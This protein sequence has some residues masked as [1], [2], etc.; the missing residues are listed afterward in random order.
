MSQAIEEKLLFAIQK[1]DVKSFNALM[2]ETQCGKFRL[3]RFPV[4]SLMYLYNSRAIISLYEEKFIKISVW[5]ELGEPASVLK[6]FS[7]KAGKCLRLYLNEVVSPL[8]MLL[9]LDR[10]GRL[11]AMYPQTNPSN[12]VK[13]RLQ[14]VYF[15]KYSLNIKFE[16]DRII[17]DRR[18]LSRREK[19]KI[20]SAC[21][22]CFLA[23]AVA[24]AVPVTT[25]SYLR[26][27]EGEITKL[28]QIDFGAKTT[29]KLKKDIIVPR[30]YSVEKV[31]CTIIGDGHKITFGENASLGEFGGKINNLIIQTSGSPIFNVCT[32]NAVL[33][34]VTINVDADVETSDSSA[35][36]A[37]ANYGTFDG[38]TVNAGGKISA[39]AG[40]AEELI[41]GGI[42]AVN[43]NVIK[44]CTVNYSDF[45]IKGQTTANASFGGIVGVNNGLVQ[46]CAVTGGI[47]AYTFDLGGACYVNYQQMSRVSNE[48][49][50]TQVSE[51]DEWAPL[52]GGLVIDNVG[53]LT[54][55][56]NSGGI[57]ALGQKEA[58]CGGI[59]ARTYYEVLYCISSG[60]ITVTAPTVY[61]GGIYGISGVATAGWNTYYFGYVDHCIAEGKITVSAGEDMSY[62]GG[63]GGYIKDTSVGQNSSVYLGGCIL[64]CVFTGAFEGE[65]DYFG[66]IV[67]VCGENIYEANSYTSGNNE[68]HNF[69]GNYYIGNG[70]FPCGAVE[71]A[72]G[73]YAPVEG[74]GAESKTAD[75][76]K[77]T[78]TYKDILE[79]LGL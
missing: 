77:D 59:V 56:K 36:I 21:L 10:T 68:Y 32:A 46:D 24:V 69:E 78:D 54:Y 18:P 1:D 12:T 30:N 48:A 9:I 64:N 3:G 42:A 27:H 22:G 45:S 39:V 79:K 74:K 60:N 55:C 14:S 72:K 40:R 34:G 13:L 15:I 26:A 76:I 65:F 44:N 62:I 29:Y 47:T 37:V 49:E 75:K 50:L 70:L 66:N 2:E 38:V 6:K 43:Y 57:S 51:T 19:K 61:A 16:G 23:V 25:V 7:S 20:L 11:K 33:S 28:S 52:V 41:F 53:I 35:L 58:V 8:E 5:E 4:L 67:G 31:N 17:L 63:I 71:T 73:E